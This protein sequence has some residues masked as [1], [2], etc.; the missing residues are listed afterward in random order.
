MA[1]CAYRRK[2]HVRCLDADRR[3]MAAKA[4]K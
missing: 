3:K 1:K 2:R 4:L